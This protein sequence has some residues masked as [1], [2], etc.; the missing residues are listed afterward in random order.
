MIKLKDKIAELITDQPASAFV[1]VVSGVLVFVICEMFMEFLMRPI[2]EYK[3]LK[4]KVA[5]DLILYSNLYHNPVNLKENENHSNWSD[6]AT[7]IRL[8]AAEVAAFAE[9]KPGH[10]FVFYAIP[11][12]KKLQ[13]ATSALI[14]ISN[15]FFAAGDREIFFQHVDE[16]ENTIRK[17]MRILK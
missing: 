12:K 17:T 3:K 9:T 16:C 11:R 14:G 13:E 5:K 15:S 6:G 4:A 10:I 1:T 7:A 8:L 2:Q